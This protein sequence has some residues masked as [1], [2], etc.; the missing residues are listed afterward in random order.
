M[1]APSIQYRLLSVLPKRIAKT[2]GFS[3][4]SEKSD[5]HVQTQLRSLPMFSF[6]SISVMNFIVFK[7]SYVGKIFPSFFDFIFFSFLKFSRA[8]L[9]RFDDASK[10]WKERGTGE[11]KF[12][13]HKD[14]KKVRF[15]MRRDK[16]L[17]ICANHY[18]TIMF[19]F[20]LQV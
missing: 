8:K 5:G 11:A 10:Q 9:F 1:V 3:T 6:N 19:I 4:C 15:L 18:G 14:T 13:Q 17:K 2:S 12:L 16:T 20:G 7:L